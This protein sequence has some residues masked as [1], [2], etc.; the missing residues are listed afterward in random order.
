MPRS[1]LR[2]KGSYLNELIQKV[3]VRYGVSSSVG[4]V[5]RFFVTLYL[6]THWSACMWVY[7]GTLNYHHGAVQQD[8][9]MLE[10]QNG[11][12]WL[13]VLEADSNMEGADPDKWGQLYF[14]AFCALLTPLWC[15]AGQPISYPFSYPLSFRS[16]C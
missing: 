4:I 13:S 6:I 11:L 15:T 16:L 2:V 14:T 8:A 1:L 10:Q 3:Q 5:I 7:L 9:E 12:T